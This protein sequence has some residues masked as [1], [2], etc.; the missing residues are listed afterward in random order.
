M[1]REYALLD[2][3]TDR[4]FGGNQ[5]AVFRDGRGISDADMQAIA[6]ELQLAETT[7]VL[8]ATTAD[9]DH[10][11][12]IFTPTESFPSPA[13]RRSAPRSSSPRAATS[14]CGWRRASASS[15]SRSGAASVK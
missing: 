15:R 9:A 14:P 10:R 4:K 7:F 12:R 2:V 3:F 5:L 8:P 1:R 6:K 13:I 11:V